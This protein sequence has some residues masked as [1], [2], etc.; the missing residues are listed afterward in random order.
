MRIVAENQVIETFRRM[1]QVVD[2]QN[3][4]DPNYRNMTPDYDGS[5]AFQAALEL[6]LKGRHASNGYTKPVLH[7][8]PP[9][10]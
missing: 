6:V 1:A 3:R 10:S 4:R 5:I 2:R 9:R 7:S 8:R